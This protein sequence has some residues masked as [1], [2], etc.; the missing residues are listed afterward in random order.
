L[1]SRV[2]FLRDNPH[3]TILHSLKIVPY[4]V[5]SKLGSSPDSCSDIQND[6]AGAQPG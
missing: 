2:N 6:L 4:L 1:N 3:D 5:V